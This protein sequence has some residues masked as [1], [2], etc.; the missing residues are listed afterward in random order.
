MLFQIIF[1]QIRLQ[2]QLANYYQ[3]EFLL[4]KINHFINNQT[5]I[6]KYKLKILNSDGSVEF[7]VFI[8]FCQIFS[9]I[10]MVLSK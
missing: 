8:N 2:S 7:T 3:E 5:V 1:L 4:L 10:F 6:Y 9:N